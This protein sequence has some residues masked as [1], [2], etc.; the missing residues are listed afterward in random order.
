LYPG[1]L[2]QSF[3]AD[4]WKFSGPLERVSRCE[5]RDLERKGQNWPSFGG[6]MSTRR[7]VCRV[8]RSQDRKR[9]ALL[10]EI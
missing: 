8:A 6:T 2:A 7:P 3:F 9:L 1:E 5:L 10:Q 4:D